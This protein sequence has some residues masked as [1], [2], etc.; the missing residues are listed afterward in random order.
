MAPDAGPAAVVQGHEMV[1]HLLVLAE[2][3]TEGIEIELRHTDFREVR[4]NYAITV[5]RMGDRAW[6]GV[7]LAQMW[8]GLTNINYPLKRLVALGLVTVAPA[9]DD[10]RTILVERTD[11]G[12]ELAEIVRKIL[13]RHGDFLLRNAGRELVGALANSATDPLLDELEWSTAL[14]RA[15]S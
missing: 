15:R 7:D 8:L 9:S 6:R 2:R 13:S 4:P 10:A 3:I 12:R 5:L 14:E 11:K 1:I